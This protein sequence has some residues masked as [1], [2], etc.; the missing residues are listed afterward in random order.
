MKQPIPTEFRP[1]IPLYITLFLEAMGSGMM[2][3]VLT[4]VARDDLGLSNFQLGTVFS[5]YN[6]AQIVGSVIMGHFADLVRRKYVMMF[7]LTWVGCG[8]ILTGFSRSF[9]WL[10]V[11]RTVTGLCGGSFSIGS[12]I[13]TA[14]I[15]PDILP[16]AI[17]RLATAASLGFA[18]GPLISSAMTAIWDIDHNSPFYLRRVY[19]F[20]IAGIYFSAALTVSRLTAKLSCPSRM[21]T[22]LSKRNLPEGSVSPGLCLIWSSRFFSTSAVTTVYVTQGYMWREYFDFNAIQINLMFAGSGVVV[23][24]IQ[25]I[26]FPFL[27]KR[28]GF[29]SSL[30]TGISCIAVACA[31]LGPLTVFTQLLSLHVMC[32]LVFW[33]GVA[34]ME[35]GTVVAVSRHL[36][37]SIE[38]FSGK[39]PLHTGLAMGITSA[40]KYAASL[41]I[42]PLAGHLYDKHRYVAHY[43]GGGIACLG[44]IAVVIAARVYQSNAKRITVTDEEKIEE[45]SLGETTE[46]T[47]Q[48]PEEEQRSTAV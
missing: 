20:V 15:E 43:L 18:I 32:L 40:M 13:L 26:V 48:N 33:F 46:T 30:L 23:S 45:N 34:C 3:A 9:T 17:G 16:F 12:A 14:N 39:R 35:P 10:I 28:I 11:S 41:S 25:G 6:A 7:T 29:H 38:S 4:V 2:A 44:I 8:Y 24:A 1:L 22:N 31:A 47:I 36:K 37:Q 5:C 42:P 19:F 21:N 27:V